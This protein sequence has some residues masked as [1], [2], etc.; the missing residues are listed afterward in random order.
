[1]KNLILWLLLAAATSPLFAQPNGKELPILSLNQEEYAQFEQLY[2][3]F[4]SN[5]EL[6]NHEWGVSGKMKEELKKLG[7]K[8]EP[9]GNFPGFLA[10]F[11]NGGTDTYYWRVELDANPHKEPEGTGVDFA[12]KVRTTHNGDSV[13]VVGSCGHPLHQSVALASAHLLVRNKHLWKGKRLGTLVEHAEEVGNG[14]SDLIQAGLFEKFGLPKGIL[15]LHNSAEIRAGKVAVVAGASPM[16]PLVM[17]VDIEVQAISGCHVGEHYKCVDVN[18]L[19]A[20]ILVRL[21]DIKNK[22]L[23]SVTEPSILGCGRICGGTR[24]NI[25]PLSCTLEFSIRCYTPEVRDKIMKHLRQI[26]E[27]E[28]MAAGAPMPK[29]TAFEVVPALVN[30]PELGKKVV[31][32]FE[33]SLGKE[34]IVPYHPVMLAEPFSK[35]GLTKDSIPILMFWLGGAKNG[36]DEGNDKEHLCPGLHS[37]NYLPDYQAALKTGATAVAN[38]FIHLFNEK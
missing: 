16:M 30:D 22:V 4:H 1:M 7:F 3:W 24:R 37:P 28:A 25:H 13:W 29:I 14:S 8:I 21:Q 32:S 27:G 11:E 38:A 35:Y 19:A 36:C 6:S 5:G 20:Q 26:A 2:K 31:A 10:I 18:L 33:K 23:N 9:L 34:N 17:N 12:S 15:S